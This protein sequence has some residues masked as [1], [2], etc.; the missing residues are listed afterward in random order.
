M[1]HRFV[2][3][4]IA[5]LL[6]ILFWGL[7]GV[8]VKVALREAD[9]RGFFLVYTIV[10]VLLSLGI[11]LWR[12]WSVGSIELSAIAALVS[13]LGFIFYME[14]I[15][16]GKVSLVVPLTS[17]SIAVAVI[18]SVVFLGEKLDIYKDVGIVL[19]I[20]AVVLLSI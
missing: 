3:W 2:D 9:W 18:L 4:R 12:G 1:L 15:N 16:V 13:L 20:L 5:T 11:L 14:A 8:L 19:A 7:Q 17:L 10:A 6:V